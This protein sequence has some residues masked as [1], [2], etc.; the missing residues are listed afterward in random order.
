MD[1]PACLSTPDLWTLT[2]FL[3]LDCDRKVA[4]N[5]RVP[6]A[7]QTCVL[8][9]RGKYSRRGLCDSSIFN[10]LTNYC[11]VVIAFLYT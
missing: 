5:D 1:I 3:S 10:F 7:T 11:L 2:S 9:F 6:V 4:V 8:I